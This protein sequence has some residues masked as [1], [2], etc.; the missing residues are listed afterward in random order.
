M[1]HRQ[2]PKLGTLPYESELDFA[3]AIDSDMALPS[4][5]VCGGGQNVATRAG[6]TCWSALKSGSPVMYVEQT[7]TRCLADPTGI[8]A[9]EMQTVS[10]THLAK[11]GSNLAHSKEEQADDNHPELAENNNLPADNGTQKVSDRIFL[12]HLECLNLDLTLLR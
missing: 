10:L 2:S 1:Y 5:P 4:P 8:V 7:H 3:L 11:D 9:T 12:T 6:F